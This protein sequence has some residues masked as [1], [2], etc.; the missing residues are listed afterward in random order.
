MEAR[1]NLKASA[2]YASNPL[3]YCLRVALAIFGADS[4]FLSPRV[5]FAINSSISTP[6]IK[7]R[8]SKVL[9]IDLDIFLPCSSSTRAWIYISLK[10]TSSMK[11]KPNIIIRA[12][13][14]K[15]ISNAVTN[16]EVG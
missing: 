4:G 12:T 1:V 3:G 7:S 10:G 13:Q 5:R 16:V 9:P 2:P 11:C 14:K 6:S 15:I 8:G